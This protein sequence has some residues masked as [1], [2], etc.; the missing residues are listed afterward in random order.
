MTLGAFV[1]SVGTTVVEVTVGGT[2]V[3]VVVVMLGTAV[4]SVGFMVVDVM[5]GALVVSVTVLGA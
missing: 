3:C 4:V 1:V 5:L 2:D